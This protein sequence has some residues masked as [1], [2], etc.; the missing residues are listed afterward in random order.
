MSLTP[1][2]EHNGITIY[3]GETFETMEQLDLIADAIIA[4][5]PYGYTDIKWDKNT[6]S[7][8]TLWKNYKRIGRNGT[9]VILTANEPFTS[10]L[11]VSN[12][13]WFRH[14][15][16]WEKDRSANFF[17]APYMPL[18]TCEDILVFNDQGY[19]SSNKTK[20]T[21]NPQKRRASSFHK[22][23]T[24]DSVQGFS[25]RQ[26]LQRPNPTL[27]RS[28]NDYNGWDRY[29]TS[30]LYFPVDYGKNRVHPTQKPLSLIAYLIRTYTLPGEIILDNTMGS[31]TTLVAAQN[32]G[33]KA[34]GIEISEKY[35]KIAEGRLKQPSFFSIPN[36]PSPTKV[37]QL[38]LYKVI[39]DNDQS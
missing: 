5:L 7:L 29:P 28:R 1:Y 11:V 20:P 31:G 23:N 22:K 15:W 9:P 2:Y 37:K 21:Y 13:K 4:D 38:D 30:K 36:K 6:I 16:V 10:L 33:R 8:D 27:G 18:A 24:S 35:C 19:A 3:C 26:I 12:M 34:V 39:T 17:N 14:K 32:E 25:S